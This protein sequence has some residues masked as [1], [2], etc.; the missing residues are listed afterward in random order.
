MY[1]KSFLHSNPIRVAT[2]WKSV[3]EKIFFSRSGKCQGKSLGVREKVLCQL[4]VRE[5]VSVSG[6]SFCRTPPEENI[7]ETSVT[8]SV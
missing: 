4:N 2:V 1:L 6:K 5:K 8:N 7:S 3:R